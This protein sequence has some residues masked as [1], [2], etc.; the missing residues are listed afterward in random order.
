MAHSEKTKT[1]RSFQI[2][3][4]QFEYQIGP[5]S[6]MLKQL[7]NTKCTTKFQK[8]Y[9]VTKIVLTYCEKNCSS[10]REKPFQIF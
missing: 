5:I 9:F 7:H 6:K 10:D 2:T 3:E 4:S 8:W 1:Q